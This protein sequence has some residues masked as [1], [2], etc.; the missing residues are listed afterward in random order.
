MQVQGS[1][2]QLKPLILLDGSNKFVTTHTDAYRELM[3]IHD[4]NRAETVAL[5]SFAQKFG[6]KVQCAKRML[7]IFTQNIQITIPG[8]TVGLHTFSKFEQIL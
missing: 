8:Q 7:M 6:L 5:S 3:D 2:L 4:D 1:K